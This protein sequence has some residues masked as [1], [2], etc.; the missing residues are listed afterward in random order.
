MV[1]TR[2]NGA[3]SVDTNTPHAVLDSNSPAM[4]PEQHTFTLH[5]IG[6]EPSEYNQQDNNTSNNTLQVSNYVNSISGSTS[7]YLDEQYVNDVTVDFLYK[8][9][10]ILA[11]TVFISILIYLALTVDDTLGQLHNTRMGV[12]VSSI[13]FLILGLLIFPSGPFIRPH[14]LVWR[15]AFGIAVLY[16][17]LLIGL[18]FQTKSDARQSLQFFHSSLGIPM[19]ERSYAAS[20][21]LTV[22]NIKG[23][24]LDIF[25]LS[26]FLGWLVK[27][28]MLRDM[29]FCWILSIQWEFMEQI[30]TPMLPNFAECWWDSWILDVL[31]CNGLGIYVGNKLCDY[32]EVKPYKFVGVKSIHTLTGKANRVAQQLFTPSSWTKVRWDRT[33][34]I[35]RFIGMQLLMLAFN[36][37]EL[38]AFFLKHLL[39]IPPE[40]KLN[41][42]RLIIWGLI[43]LPAI[44]QIYR[45][46]TDPTC[47]K[48]GYQTFLCIC[49]L[50]TELIL[51][52]KLSKNEFP[53]PYTPYTL[54]L[55]GGM[56][57]VYVI[58]IIYMII[59]IKRKNSGK[60]S[61]MYAVGLSRQTSSQLL[62]DQSTPRDLHSIRES[63]P[64]I[65]A[66]NE[67]RK[68]HDIDSIDD[69]NKKS[70]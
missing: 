30:F 8:P 9:H 19:H 21:D 56:I 48:I 69:N 46:V 68:S 7:L 36:L 28:L 58:Y 60:S 50:F 49:I 64:Q 16:E 61:I 63:H 25:A 24:A 6:S 45:Y 59:E 5:R 26:H 54:K 17:M 70:Q 39:W 20:C 41:L 38:N 65:D 67:R 66:R 55:A 10:T 62:L 22:D 32:Y 13:F 11:A 51:I 4:I 12:F 3:I 33:T 52:I 18:L 35:N 53:V 14:P 2:S 43:G 37:E 57:S 29:W 44:R 40:N 1:T 15:L 47:R 31:I 34:N 23:A 42:C 27:S